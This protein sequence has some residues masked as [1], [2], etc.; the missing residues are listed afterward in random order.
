MVLE[1]I[2]S[3]DIYSFW[4]MVA[5]IVGAVD[6]ELPCELHLP[7][8]GR[9]GPRCGRKGQGTFLSLLPP[10]ESVCLPGTTE[11]SWPQGV[12]MSRPDVSKLRLSLA[13][14]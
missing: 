3:V 14:E 11:L 2:A 6:G 9:E 13:S 8:R 7:V 4:C 10:G 12:L 1:M 5:M